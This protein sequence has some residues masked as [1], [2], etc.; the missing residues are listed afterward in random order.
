MPQGKGTYGTTRGRPPKK[1]LKPAPHPEPAPMPGERPKFKGITKEEGR[2]HAK[3]RAGMIQE[4]KEKDERGNRHAGKEVKAMPHRAGQYT[5]KKRAGVEVEPGT[6]KKPKGTQF[7]ELVIAT[8]ER[9]PARAKQVAAKR[10]KRRRKRDD[11]PAS[12]NYEA[13]VTDEL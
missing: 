2:F 8:P 10:V 9:K 11:E 5:E 3:K 4:Y 13:G 1:K 7:V 6:F 12:W